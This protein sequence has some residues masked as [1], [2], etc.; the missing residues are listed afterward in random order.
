MLPTELTSHWWQRPGRRPGREQYHWHILFHDQP[1]VA[2]LAAMAQR[3]LAGLS[4]LDPVPT[5]WLHLTTL[6]VG[7][8]DE[9]DQ[10]AVDAMVGQARA[11]LAAVRPVRVSLGRVFY[12]PEAVV[13]PVEPLRALDPVLDAVTAAC[14]AAGLDGQPDTR[15]WLPHVSVAYA[16]TCAPAAPVIAALGRRLPPAQVTVRS[17]SLVAQT[18]VGR[19]WQWRPVAEVPLAGR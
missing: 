2:A 14:A 9:T 8:A 15:P 17:V 16:N 10:S 5:R 3:K 1:A 12:H 4:C 13:L 7:F 19:S 6:V 18:Q 11:L